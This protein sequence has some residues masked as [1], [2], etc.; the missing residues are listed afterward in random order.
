MGSAF[1]IPILH[2]AHL[3]CHLL[4][5]N[6][7]VA[8]ANKGEGIRNLRPAQTFMPHPNLADFLNLARTCRGCRFL[9]AEEFTYCIRWHIAGTVFVK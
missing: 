7:T 5:K 4:A 2:N 1:Q 9:G 8:Q 3:F 6:H